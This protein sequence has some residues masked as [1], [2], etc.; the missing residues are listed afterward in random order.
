VFDLPEKEAG[1]LLEAYQG[2]RLKKSI[3][4]SIEAITELPDI[5]E[6]SDRYKGGMKSRGGFQG[7]S[8]RGGYKERENESSGFGQWRKEEPTKT[9]PPPARPYTAAPIKQT[10]TSSRE[11]PIPSSDA[12]KVVE[13]VNFGSKPV[14]FSKKASPAD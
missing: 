14:F 1:S 2:A 9:A 5:I 6:T 4:F 8:A 13:G 10:S 11:D 7:G 12:P 3:T